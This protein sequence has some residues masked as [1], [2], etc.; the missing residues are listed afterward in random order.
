MAGLF[1]SLIVYMSTINNVARM[2]NLR[3]SLFL[4]ACV[5][6]WVGLFFFFYMPH[7]YALFFPIYTFA[8]LS[9]PICLYGFIRGF[10]LGGLERGV[11]M[12][13]ALPGLLGIFTI[14][15]G[16]LDM[17]NN[18][19]HNFGGTWLLPVKT[20]FVVFYFIL[21][22]L[23]LK[24]FRSKESHLDPMTKLMP[25]RWLRWLIAVMALQ[26][27]NLLLLYLSKL[28][29]TVHTWMLILS[30]LPAATQV[31]V[32]MYATM[33]KSYELFEKAESRLYRKRA[34]E[35][36]RKIEQGETDILPDNVSNLPDKHAY[37]RRVRLSDKLI[38]EYLCK[39]K[40]Y[41]N[42]NLT[43][44]QLADAL[45]TNRTYL[46]NYINTHYGLNFSKLVNMCRLKELRRLAALPKN[47]D[48]A[49]GK[50][51]GQAGFNN[52]QHYLRA[53]NDKD[54]VEQLENNKVFHNMR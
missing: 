8:C 19:V 37:R 42:P 44:L 2:I 20:L 14:V 28:F 26:I 30:S 25:V 50:L 13:F 36:V 47:H 45:H 46:S 15:I 49:L 3:L 21:V 9:M 7:L 43:L 35:D 6:T 53:K 11:W 12:H 27:T 39:R 40:L 1:V 51:V 38:E 33:H 17:S 23:E 5:L 10:T 16:V 31:G 24:T 22:L 4:V 52:Y 29:G 32:M 54:I 41:L 48:T 34:L 18:D